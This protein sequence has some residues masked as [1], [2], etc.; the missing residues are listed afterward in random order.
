MASDWPITTIGT[1]VDL[2][3]G[4]AFKSADYT[5]APDGVRLLRGDNI[6][7]GRLR[8]DGLRRWPESLN[9][10]LEKYALKVGD[11][12]IAMDRPWIEAG[13]KYARI[14]DRDA[15]SLLVQR[16]TRLR[17]KERLSQDFVYW[18]IGSRRFSDYVQAVQTGTAVPHISGSQIAGFEFSLPPLEEQ[19]RIAGVLG[20]LEAKIDH[21]T[22]IVR[23]LG[24]A[25]HLRSTFL[26]REATEWVP[27]TS[28]ARFVNGR[29]FTKEANGQGL[30]ILRIRELKAGIDASTPRSE[31]S[32]HA[33]NI[34]G[35]SD[36]LFAWS[37]SLGV[38]RWGGPDALINQHIFKVIPAGGYP[39]WLA[40]YWVLLH[41]GEF[42]A[43]AADKATT[44]GHIQRRHL[45]E[46][47]VPLP[48]KDVLHE[49]RS[50]VDALDGLRDALVRETTELSAARDSLSP[51]LLSGRLRVSASFNPIDALTET[52]EEAA[53]EAA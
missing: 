42:Q 51:H 11:V 33:D 21:N 49:E 14:L 26:T 20:A 32:A 10:G 47:L 31:I 39:T 16:V 23:L 46:A 29:A 28:V 24:K 38:Y 15:P 27:L 17:A 53:G 30:P 13:L 36:L 41:L 19:L 40:E 2:L 45:D 1:E 37:G 34:A 22:E 6:I 12:V 3:P 7:Q 43:I 4:F 35:A 48:K 9:K 52:A 25:V 5:D 50:T 18:L 8:W 44:M